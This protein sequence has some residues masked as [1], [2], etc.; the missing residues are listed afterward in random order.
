MN[1]IFGKKAQ[2]YTE[3][4]VD[5]YDELKTKSAYRKYKNSRKDKSH[6]DKYPQFV[7]PSRFY[8]YLLSKVMW[9]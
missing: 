6:L 1:C 4:T 5:Y 2:K 3:T 8:N 7:K 9:R